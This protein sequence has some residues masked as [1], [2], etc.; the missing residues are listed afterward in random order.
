[1]PPAQNG[2]PLIIP[3]ALRSVS[4]GT[5]GCRA[6]ID[7]SFL[8]FWGEG[9]EGWLELQS[10]WDRTWDRTNL[11]FSVAEISSR[12]PSHAA[13]RVSFLCPDPGPVNPRP[14]V[15][16]P[17]RGEVGKT[18]RAGGRRPR[19]KRTDRPKGLSLFVAF[20]FLRLSSP[21]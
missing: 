12:R 9:V 20:R 21:S 1:M 6:A 16:S 14:D 18:R 2:P 13:S 15:V 5:V 7:G 11:P 3:S 19:R 17:T 10:R 8:F 4:S